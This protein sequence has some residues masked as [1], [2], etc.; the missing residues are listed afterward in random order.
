MPPKKICPSSVAE[1]PEAARQVSSFNEFR[2]AMAGLGCS[3]AQVGAFWKQI[4]GGATATATQSA[5]KKRKAEEAEL[6]PPSAK[7]SAT[8]TKVA[9]PKKTAAPR[10]PRK[11]IVKASP[12][13]VA[14]PKG[15]SPKRASPKAATPQ[16]P[17][18]P[19]ALAVETAAFALACYAD[20]V[21][22]SKCLEDEEHG[23]KCAKSLR[24]KFPDL[25]AC[26]SCAKKQSSAEASKGTAGAPPPPPPPPPPMPKKILTA[27]KETTQDF[28]GASSLVS[29]KK[30]IVGMMKGVQLKKVVPPTATPAFQAMPIVAADGSITKALASAPNASPAERAKLGQ[31]AEATDLMSQ[32]LAKQGKLKATETE[33]KKAPAGPTGIFAE[34]LS[35]GGMS[36]LKKTDAAPKSAF[37]QDPF[38]GN[39][40]MSA[41]AKRLGSM[42]STLEQ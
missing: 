41:L 7:K 5:S 26:P 25:F 19:K 38:A 36:S 23:E 42:R 18:S 2:S 32:I 9:T 21:D 34:L 33:A 39:D 28:T 11:T 35:K 6:E 27:M 37:K 1:L 24:K 15:P 12:T 30:G 10:T 29:D 20:G 16:K 8:T 13:K 40:L 14:S 4:S 3:A 31:V 17:A 22:W